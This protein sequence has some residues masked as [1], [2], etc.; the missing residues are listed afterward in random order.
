MRNG[1]RNAAL[2]LVIVA[3][4]GY[5]WYS[6]THLSKVEITDSVSKT[7][8]EKLDQGDL[9][10]YHMH[11][12]KLTVLHEEGNKYKGLA[13]VTYDGKGHEVPVDIVADG[14]NLAWEVPA[15]SFMFAAQEQ[16]RKSMADAQ[17]QIRRAASDAQAA[18]G[19]GSSKSD[20]YDPKMPDPIASLA[21]QWLILN[22][23]CRGGA[24]GDSATQDACAAREEKYADIRSAGWCW[25]HKDDIGADRKWV[26]CRAGDD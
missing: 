24:G 5:A 21:A 10:E 9:S 25:G 7:L 22:D 11:L 18:M 19:A 6:S 17:D 13:I 12:E 23:K 8:Q 1:I 4:A 26:E 20:P 15:G 14:K 3:A 16:F 2:G